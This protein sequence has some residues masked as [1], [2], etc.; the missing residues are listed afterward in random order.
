MLRFSCSQ[1]VVERLDPLVT[2]GL[3]PSPHVHQIVGGN[4]FN[5]T[6]DPLNDLPGISTCTT[7]TFSEDFSN[8][9]TAV[10]YFRGRNGTFKRVPQMANLYLE[11]ATGGQTV[12]YIPPYDGVTNVTA[13]RPGFRMLVGDPNARSD[14]H[15]QESR[16][17]SFRCFGEGFEGGQG[18]P[19]GGNDTRHFPKGPCT[20]GIRSNIFFPTC[21]DGVN[22]DSPDHKSHVSFPANNGSFERNSPCPA[23]HPIKIPQLFYEI[24]WDTR[25]FNN[26]A[27]WPEDGSQ[28]FVFSTGDATGYGQHADY[29]FGWKGDALQRAMDQ[30]CFVNCPTLEAQATTAANQCVQG[31]HVDE[32]IDGWLDQLPGGHEITWTE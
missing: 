26:P 16:Q 13:F 25:Q 10:L 5:A 23:S 11:G 1:L 19:G 24:L 2:P 20:G 17:S 32:V 29:V 22:L 28:P 30:R 7:C 14:H 18:P 15:T 27:E 3:N 12:Y 6:M 31:K 4:A 21:W 9:W 8:Y